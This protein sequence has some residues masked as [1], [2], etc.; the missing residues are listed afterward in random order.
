MHRLQSELFLK[1]S[2]NVTRCLE[3]LPFTP[4][5]PHFR[6]EEK[7]AGEGSSQQGLRSPAVSPAPRRIPARRCH[8]E[9]PQL[10]F[11]VLSGFTFFCG[12]FGSGKSHSGQPNTVV[13]SGGGRLF[14]KQ[15]R[16]IIFQRSTDPFPNRRGIEGRKEKRPLSH[17]EF[18]FNM[19]FDCM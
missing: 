6:V 12:V 15:P 1:E 19:L 10:L 14:C 17:G 16:H 13:V 9:L 11:V 2:Y 3:A 4:V 18:P 7:E 5:H 8:S